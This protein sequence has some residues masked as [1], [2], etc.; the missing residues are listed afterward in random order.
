[1][2]D[3]IDE[4]IPVGPGQG[5][6]QLDAKIAEQADEISAPSGSDRSSAESVLQ[7]QVPA[8][9]PGN[10]LAQGGVTIGICRA[11][12]RNH[13]SKF[14]V[15]QSGKN[16]AD[17][18]KDEGEHDG[19]SG[20]LCRGRARNH[21][22]PGT[23]D[24][25]DSERNQVSRTQSSPETVFTCVMRLREDQ[26]EWLCR[27]QIGHSVLLRYR[28]AEL[29]LRCLI[30]LKQKPLGVPRGSIRHSNFVLKGSYREAVL[31]ASCCNLL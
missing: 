7:H 29:R 18:S 16:A 31:G 28:V 19:G 9:D 8:D 11:G 24:R 20:V 2:V 15:T 17:S 4:I 27:Q 22:D 3:V 12:H 6:R 13:G 10:D 25:P 21:E 1:M 26:V 23:D 5:S 14:G 30:I